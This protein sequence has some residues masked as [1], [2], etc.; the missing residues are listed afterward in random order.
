MRNASK[1]ANDIEPFEANARGFLFYLV[2]ILAFLFIAAVALS[3]KTALEGKASGEFPLEVRP[4]TNN[5]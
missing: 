1:Q 2:S 5:P 4:D 3:I